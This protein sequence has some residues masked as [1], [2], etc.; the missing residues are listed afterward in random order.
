MSA[1]AV[2]LNASKAADPV[3]YASLSHPGVSY[4]YD[5]F[6]QAGQAIRN[7]PSVLGGLESRHLIADGESQ[8]VGRM[9]TYVNAVQPLAHAYDGFL[10]H[11]RGATGSALAQ[12]PLT[13]IPV[14]SPAPIRTDGP[15]P[16]RVLQSE[17]DVN[18]GA[19]QDDTSTFRLWEMAGTAHVDAYTLGIGL[20]D[21]GDGQV[22]IAMFNAMRVPPAAGCALPI[23]TGP[24]HWLVQDAM[25][26][27]AQW[28]RRGR[29][30][31]HAPRIEVTSFT[32]RTYARDANDNVLGG[33]RTPL[34]DVPVAN[35]S[36]AGQSGPGLLCQLVGS[37]IPFSDAKLASLYESHDSSV[38]Q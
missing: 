22:D 28:V 23:N 33:I 13:P 14:P 29:E 5:M 18:A 7:D 21:V 10:V 32:P 35:V 9:V 8:S 19:R 17:T 20:V 4:S 16:V 24:S 38:K 34:V 12:A 36:V 11:S 31:A 1:Q 26:R 15:S 27:L 3:R 6:T 25:V 2:G 37:T 30:P